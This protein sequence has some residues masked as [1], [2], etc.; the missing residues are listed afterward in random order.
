MN[1][2]EVTKN[3]DIC[4]EGIQSNYYL[5]G[6]ISAFENRFQAVAD[7]MMKEISWKQFFVIICISMCKN[8]PTINELSDIVG[9]SHQN[10]KQ[11]LIKLESKKFIKIYTDGIDKRKQKI[12]LTDYCID[13]CEKNDI[14]SLSIMNQMFKG[15]SD[16]ELETTIKTI[17]KIEKNMSGEDK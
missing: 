8:D 3:E 15:I 16:K 2:L 4:L 7:K 9:S 10:I 17:S 13:F 12:C 14:N 5:L 6:L 11:I 1:I